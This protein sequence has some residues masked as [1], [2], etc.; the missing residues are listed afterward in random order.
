MTRLVSTDYTYTHAAAS[1]THAYLWRPVFSELKTR[2]CTKVFDLGCG[3][4]ALARFLF[5]HGIEVTGVDP[6]ETGIS[7][8]KNSA[9]YLRLE[10]GSAYD[11][12]RQRFGTF[13]AVV[14]LEVIEHVYYPR[15]YAA[16]IRDLLEP[17]GVAL[18]S[19]PYHGYLKNLA[20]AVAGRMDAHFTALWDHGHIKFW[21]HRT[22]TTLL[23]ENG[24][25]VHQILRLGRI[26][27][28]A[29]SM[30]VIAQKK[31]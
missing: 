10:L 21:S 3:N 9:P 19:T 16:C 12:L 25:Q 29:K 1:H 8:C 15:K 5:D 28:L 31:Q 13:P 2:G 22:I 11:N 6:S 23:A 18:I 17:G 20:I 30:L 27:A 14:S 24:L 7:V 4:G 26:P